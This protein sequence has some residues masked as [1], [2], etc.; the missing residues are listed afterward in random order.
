MGSR[1]EARHAL[2]SDCFSGQEKV[3]GKMNNVA[4]S[5]LANAAEDVFL[6]SPARELRRD[7][8]GADIFQCPPVHVQSLRSVPINPQ[9]QVAWK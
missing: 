1:E 8:I 5:H 9:Q 6:T 4:L 3:V 2:E 7:S